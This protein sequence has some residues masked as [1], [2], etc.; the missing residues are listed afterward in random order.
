MEKAS[1]II[2]ELMSRKEFR[3]KRD[4]AD[5]FGVSPQA[6]SIW[7]AKGTIPPKH[8]LKLS[9]ENL[10]NEKSE[11]YPAQSE[12]MSSESESKTVIDYLM[13]E[14]VKLKQEIESLKNSQGYAKPLHQSRNL[15]DKFVADSM[16]REYFPAKLFTEKAKQFAKEHHQGGKK[17]ILNN[18]INYEQFCEIISVIAKRINSSMPL[19]D[20]LQLLF[21]ENLHTSL[22]MYACCGKIRGVRIKS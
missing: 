16:T 3:R 5:F 1:D 4:V 18:Y 6:L 15:I 8:L 2:N 22:P 19:H 9:K 12:S 14:N 13:R 20:A 17:R 11:H 7:I 10:V 21:D